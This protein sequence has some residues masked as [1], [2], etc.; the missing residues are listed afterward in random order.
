MGRTDA[1]IV[2]ELERQ[3]DLPWDQYFLPKNSDLIMWEHPTQGRVALIVEDDVL[4]G[5]IAAFL[6]R[7]GKVR[8][9]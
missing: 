9:I 5:E 1:D 2:A 8:E 6:R 7:N 3:G 4:A